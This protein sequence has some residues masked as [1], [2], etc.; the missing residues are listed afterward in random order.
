MATN[1]SMSD[2]VAE[3]VE[4]TDAELIP[5]EATADPKV[6]TAPMG[7]SYLLRMKETTAVSPPKAIYYLL[8][9]A[10]SDGDVI[11]GANSN[12]FPAIAEIFKKARNQALGIDKA[13]NSV[14]EDLRKL[15]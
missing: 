8:Q 5:W 10:D 9:I 1:V 4:K 11:V 14:I 6:F 7:G 13:I 3:V 15:K 12:S 2:L